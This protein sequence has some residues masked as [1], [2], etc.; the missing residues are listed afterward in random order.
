MPE[1]FH[2]SLQA[3]HFR[4]IA[5]I[6]EAVDET[7]EVQHAMEKVLDVLVEV[8][9]CDSAWVA[10]SSASAEG[11]FTITAS[12]ARG[13]IE[14]TLRPNTK[15]ARDSNYSSYLLSQDVFN[16]P[17]IL[18]TE[19][20]RELED[21]AL[22]TSGIKSHLVVGLRLK[23]ESKWIL[24][25]N[26]S[27]RAHAWSDVELELVEVGA[28]RTAA[29]LNN[30]LAN[31]ELQYREERLQLAI[32]AAGDGVWD[33]HVEKGE[34]VFS[35]SWADMLGYEISEMPKTMAGFEA[36]VHPDDLALVRKSLLDHLKGLSP[37][38]E[39]E[40]RMRNKSGEYTWVLD[41]GRVVEKDDDGNPLRVLGT[42]R[43]ISHTKHAEEMLLRE[44]RL[45]TGGPCV[46]F[47]WVAA[48][49]WPVE[50]V[51]PNVK[52][53]FGYSAEEFMT[54][55]VP[56][57]ETVFGNDLK[58]VASEVALHTETGIGVF[59]QEYR[60]VRAD[61]EVRWLYDFT[62][63]NRDEDGKV[64]HY[65]GY[66]L[67][68]TERRNAEQERLE[69]VKQMQHAQKLESLGVLAGGIAHDFNNLLMGVLG[70]ADLALDKM[71][72][73]PGAAESVEQI[74]VAAHQAADLTHQLLAYAGKGKYVTVALEVNHAI[75]EMARLLEVTLTGKA[76]MRFDLDPG[77]PAIQ[78]D[79]SQ[80]GQVVMNL[81]TNAADAIGDNSGTISL[82]TSVVDLDPD[83]ISRLNLTEPILGGFYVCIE[84]SDNGCGMDEET[85]AKIFEPF[86]T[87]KFTGRG[88]GMAAVMGIVKAHGGALKVRSEVGVG[89]KIKVYFPAT[90]RVPKLP[91]EDITDS[92]WRGQGTV[93]LVDDEDA[94]R[95][96]SSLMLESMGFDVLI[97]AD[98][99]EALEIYAKHKSEIRGVLLDLTMPN[100]SG[101]EVF[102]ELRKM[103]SQLPVIL[104]SGYNQS[105]V[106]RNFAGRDVV[107]FLQKPYGR[108]Q[109]TK[110]MQSALP[111]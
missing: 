49:G 111:V 92:Q 45:F 13:P 17:L 44:R 66:V 86:F 39:C 94:I 78:A 37:R 102:H 100:V 75:R 43:N 98:G 85:Q 70:H 101:E 50:Y 6:C 72:S 91:V 12:V 90:S 60:I 93:L 31:K 77:L 95:R 88:L 30:L 107:H 59:E 61:G 84:V 41:R 23:G 36:L 69:L 80:F 53:L 97:A 76:D 74:K 5:R 10:E 48:D 7:L 27:Q 62:V 65:E 2:S 87:T 104:S 19:K 71:E 109:L 99:L 42:R 57:S 14:L 81:I 24:C 22:V 68:A 56:Y 52:E 110:V 63:V 96:V 106:V 35:E 58:R 25:L 15:F 47:R 3:Q 40:H 79:R 11:E 83:R 46:V 1:R 26:H 28:Q 8:F 54:G 33:W 38:Y 89:T 73:Q 4:S 18:P 34:L 108:R 67:D 82:H 21:E 9:E 105:D 103:D 29:A 32:E 64:T 20:L 51:S 16:A 55:A